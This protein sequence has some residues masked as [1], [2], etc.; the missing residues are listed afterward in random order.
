MVGDKRPHCL[1]ALRAFPQADA[2]QFTAACLGAMPYTKSFPI[3]LTI[4]RSTYTQ[5]SD[6]I[7]PLLPHLSTRNSQWLPLRLRVV[8]LLRST[9]PSWTCQTLK[10]VERRSPSSLW[11]L[12][13]TAV[14]FPSVECRA[15]VNICCYS[16]GIGRKRPPKVKPALAF[17]GRYVDGRMP[18]RSHDRL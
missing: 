14:S 15:V 4:L 7:W 13:Q 9:R 18:H 11:T 8:L 17:D 10:S 1:T 5:N 16:G 3:R 12:L 2:R 6:G